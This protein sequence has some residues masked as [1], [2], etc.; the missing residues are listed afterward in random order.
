MLRICNNNLNVTIT[1]SSSFF[2][3][4]TKTIV[5]STDYQLPSDSV[6]LC[7]CSAKCWLKASS[8][9]KQKPPHMI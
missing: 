9:H 1:T 5:E 4:I 8:A 3:S 6:N 2:I 7:M